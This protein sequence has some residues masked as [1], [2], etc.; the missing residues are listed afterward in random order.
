MTGPAWEKEDNPYQDVV[1]A[2]GS[3]EGGRTRL[4]RISISILINIRPSV[5]GSAL[6]IFI[7]NSRQRISVLYTE[8][9]VS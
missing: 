4:A 7:G 6:T 1:A 5:T 9:L 8:I 3:P 2:M